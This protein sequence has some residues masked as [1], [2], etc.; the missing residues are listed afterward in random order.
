MSLPRSKRESIKLHI[1]GKIS[2]VGD[3]NVKRV[4]GDLGVSLTTV[5]RYI[6]ELEKN[7]VIAIKKSNNRK[8]ELVNDTSTFFLTLEKG[9]TDESEAY[10]KYILPLVECLPRNVIEIWE[11]AFTEMVNN[12]IEHSGGNSLFITVNK[13]AYN[14]EI[15]LQDN[16]IGIFKKIKDYFDYDSV[17]Q[18]VLEL[19]KGKLTTDSQS[20]TGE[21]IFFTSR[22]LDYFL[23]W[24]N[25]EYFSHNNFYDFQGD[26]KKGG[27][28]TIVMSQENHNK[29]TLAE[30]FDMYADVDGGFTV[31]QIPLVKIFSNGYPIS[32]SQAN[33]L[34]YR[35]ES[36][37]VV[38]LDFVGIE[39]IGQG[40]ADQLFRVFKNNHNEVELK[41]INANP[42]VLRMIKRVTV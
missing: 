22:V 2:E 34:A 42:E 11:Y 31:T 37:E 23:I 3:V 7:G 4:A 18:A 41:V 1:L 29:G 20:H 14:I 13:N 6:N 19:F 24:S 16:G 32:R 38:A 26:L 21:G 8:Y 33:R 30:V 9:K 28:T 12:A 36:F 10:E 15:I 5:Y 17:D 27:G 40:F 25:D 35:F 39:N